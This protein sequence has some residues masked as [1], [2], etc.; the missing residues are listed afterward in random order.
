MRRAG[1]CPGQEPT[2]QSDLE[3]SWH[4]LSLA[5][6]RTGGRPLTRGGLCE[7]QCSQPRARERREKYDAVCGNAGVCARVEENT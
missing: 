6:G 1:P 3:G 7:V 2:G 4:L 5:P